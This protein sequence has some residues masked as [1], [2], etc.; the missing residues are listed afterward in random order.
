M[1]LAPIDLGLY[2][3]KSLWQDAGVPTHGER[4]IELRGLAGLTLEEAAKAAGMDHE[5]RRGDRGAGNKTGMRSLFLRGLAGTHGSQRERSGNG[6]YEHGRT[7]T[8]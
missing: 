6:W 3:D 4:L 1:C 5:R 7:I 2:T 8:A